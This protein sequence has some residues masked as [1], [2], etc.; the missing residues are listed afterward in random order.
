MKGQLGLLKK[1]SVK[2]MK[3]SKKLISLTNG[4]VTGFF[5]Q[6]F[7]KVFVFQ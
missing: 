4:L 6:K 5:G 2:S 1:Q 7:L 3:K